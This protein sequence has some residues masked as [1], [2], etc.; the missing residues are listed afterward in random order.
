MSGLLK[1]EWL[2]LVNNKKLPFFLLVV[3]TIQ[4]LPVVMTL[5]LNM[6]TLNGQVYPLTMFG[7]LVSFALPLFLL[8]LVAEI[9]TEEHTA[10]LLALSLLHP[11]TRFKV[12]T[13]KVIFLLTVILGL[14]LFAMLLGYAVGTLLFGWGGEFM[15]RGVAFTTGQGIAITF[16]SYLAAA[17]PQ[18]AFSQLVM[19]LAVLINSS[20]A[21]TG[22][23]AGIFMSA[24]M[25][26]LLADEIRP[27]LLTSY[28]NTVPVL[29]DYAAGI[30]GLCDFFA[31]PALCALAF[32]LLTVLVFGRKDMLY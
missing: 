7:L 17:L 24:S 4:L 9:V 3:A 10:G 32:F 19:F 20:A 11:V 18:L 22:I 27:F 31:F 8:I 29:T 25:L 30:T 23:A 26:M 1:N 15:L 12:I 14:L 16:L 6:R 28:F 13:A 21:V 5:F 2:K